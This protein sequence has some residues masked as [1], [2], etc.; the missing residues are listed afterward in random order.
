MVVEVAA[1]DEMLYAVCS[2]GGNEAN[3]GPERTAKGRQQQRRRL[4]TSAAA[5]GIGV[6]VN[7]GIDGLNGLAG[8]LK[9]N[10]DEMDVAALANDD[11]GDGDVDG[12]GDGDGD[13]P[14]RV[15]HHRHRRPLYR[16]FISYMRSAWTAGVNFSS[17]NGTVRNMCTHSICILAVEGGDRC[18]LYTFTR[19]MEDS[20][21]YIT[22]HMISIMYEM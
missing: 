1:L 2:D 8:Q 12:D 22:V 10:G 6:D 9:S 15:R 13:E 21:T 19:H 4:T 18:T 7:D 5:D 16:R 14:K 17:S 11:G 3:N 20:N